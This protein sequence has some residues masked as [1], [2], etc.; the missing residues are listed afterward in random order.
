MGFVLVIGFIDHLQ[1]V[2]TNDYNSLA[3]LRILKI[4]ATAAYIKSSMS[5]LVVSW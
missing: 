5:S 4:T 3:G 1:I 2:T